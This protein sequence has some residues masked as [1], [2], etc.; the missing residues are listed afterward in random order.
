MD[1]ETENRLASLLLEEARRL[2]LEANREGVHAYLRKP[3]N[4][5]HRPNSR[6]LTATVRGAQHG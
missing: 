4:V 2:Q 1:L 3:N 5:R 6:L